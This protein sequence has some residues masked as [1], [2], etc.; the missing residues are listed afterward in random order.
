MLK[1]HLHQNPNKALNCLLLPF[2]AFSFTWVEVD[3]QLYRSTF[4]TSASPCVPWG[5]ATFTRA[6]GKPHTFSWF[7]ALP[8][9]VHLLRSGFARLSQEINAWRAQKLANH[10]VPHIGTGSKGKCCHKKVA[11]LFKCFPEGSKWMPCAHCTVFFSNWQRLC[12][13]PCLKKQWYLSKSFWFPMTCPLPPAFYL[14]LCT[15]FQF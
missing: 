4:S 5:W 1:H 13:G 6:S 15:F 2:T 14:P 7:S 3:W 11:R 12:C 9:Y 10:V 8:S